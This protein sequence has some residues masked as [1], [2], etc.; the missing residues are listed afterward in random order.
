MSRVY[1]HTKT[2]EA[3]LRG[4]ERAYAGSVCGKLFVQS[5]ELNDTWMDETSPLKSILVPDHY[6]RDYEGKQ[7]NKTLQT[8]CGTSMGDLFIV[9]GVRI[10]SFSL[11][12]NTALIMGSDEVKLLARIH[13]QSEIHAFI[14]GTN[15]AWI[16]GLIQNGRKS[17]LFRDGQGWESVAE[18]LLKDDSEPVVM[19]YSVCESFPNSSVT[20]WVPPYDEESGED[21]HDAWYDL[22]DAERWQMSLD[23]IRKQ[24]GLELKPDDWN[25]F[26]FTHGINGFQLLEYAKEIMIAKKPEMI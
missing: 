4:S 9:E 18:L 7:F 25:S 20:T 14:E 10:N 3:E 12:L 24:K 23:A 21:I 11:M 13:G 2:E 17:G 16:A 1:F 6:T 26:Y 5:V 19:S 22:T 15:R 8:A